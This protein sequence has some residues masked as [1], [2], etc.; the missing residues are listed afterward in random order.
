VET[1]GDLSSS[2]AKIRSWAVTMTYLAEISSCGN[3]YGFVF[4]LTCFFIFTGQ[5]SQQFTSA[6][7]KEHRNPHQLIPWRA[8]VGKGGEAT[9]GNMSSC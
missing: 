5:P 1:V 6:W 7:V 2:W 4:N 3:S 8:R 9:R